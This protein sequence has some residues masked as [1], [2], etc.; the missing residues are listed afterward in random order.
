MYF[1]PNSSRHK[2]K[3]TF[4]YRTTKLERL[5]DEADPA[6]PP[7]KYLVRYLVFH[8]LLV[9]FTLMLC[10]NFLFPFAVMM[11][12]YVG[13]NLKKLRKTWIVF[14]SGKVL[15]KINLISLLLCLLLFI[16]GKIFFLFLFEDVI[17]KALT[18]FWN[19]FGEFWEDLKYKLRPV[20][21]ISDNSIGIANV[22]SF[23]R[24]LW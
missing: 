1:E 19:V 6:N 14:Y 10:M 22:V 2:P 20:K 12:L 13:H 7:K 4:T 8:W 3:Q 23:A 11:F 9:F 16:P 5:R 21:K 15:T 18:W 24:Q 17:F